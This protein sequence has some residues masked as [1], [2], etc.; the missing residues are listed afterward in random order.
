LIAPTQA[1]SPANFAGY[2]PPLLIEPQ[3]YEL[4]KSQHNAQELT[5][6]WE[7]PGELTDQLSFEI[8]VWLEGTHPQGVYDAKELKHNPTFVPLGEHQ[9]AVTLKL[10][11]PGVTSTSSDYFWSVGVVQID[12]EY[13]WLDLESEARR[14]S[15]LVP[16]N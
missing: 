4:D 8:R 2:A 5:F 1:V 7:W 6:I 10:S 12:P 9:Y 3:P 14:I 13:K 16:G 11:S 15:L